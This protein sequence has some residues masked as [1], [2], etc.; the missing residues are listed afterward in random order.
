ML[1]IMIQLEMI[2]NALKAGQDKNIGHEYSKDVES[3]YREEHRSII[4]TPWPLI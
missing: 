3:R 4:P 1:E 2:D